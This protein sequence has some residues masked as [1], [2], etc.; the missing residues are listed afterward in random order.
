MILK[1]KLIEVV[2][3]AVKEYGV[4][5]ALKLINDEVRKSSSSL[6]VVKCLGCKDEIQINSSIGAIA[7]YLQCKTC[8]DQHIFFF[9]KCR[10]SRKSGPRGAGK[11]LSIRYFD[12]LKN[13]RLF[14][15]HTRGWGVES[16]E[17]RSKDDFFV[18]ISIPPNSMGSSFKCDILIFNEATGREYILSES[19]V[20]NYETQ[21][22]DLKAG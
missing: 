9:G 6:R 13:E 19:R 21:F 15:F 20:P 18:L 10:A 17:I 1:D 2:R 3:L 12:G 11:R 4:D 22:P 7:T 5:N 14:E 8:C 16:L